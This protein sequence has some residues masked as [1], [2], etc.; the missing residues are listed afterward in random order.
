M[1]AALP[2]IKIIP[3]GFSRY[4][5]RS[6][7]RTHTRS[8]LTWTGNQPRWDLTSE[9]L[10][11]YE[12]ESH[13]RSALFSA[14]HSWGFWSWSVHTHLHCMGSPGPWHVKPARGIPTSV[15]G[16][17]CFVVETRQ[18]D[19]GHSTWTVVTY[20][21]LF[22]RSFQASGFHY[23]LNIPSSSQPRSKSLHVCYDIST[24]EG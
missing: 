1:T 17:G 21:T 2:I 14:K 10:R 12:N 13:P 16:F 15:S 20:Y 11:L 9:T 18:M 23:L 3:D 24:G 6:G 4:V 7:G 5:D 22:D 8:R 19:F